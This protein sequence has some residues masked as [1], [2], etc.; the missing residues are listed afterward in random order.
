MGMIEAHDSPVACLEFNNKGDRLVTASAKG[1]VFRVFST[2]SGDKLFE[3]RRGFSS[4][5]KVSSMSF[6]VCVL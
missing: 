1:T 2:P 6:S 4:Y 5:A 3:L